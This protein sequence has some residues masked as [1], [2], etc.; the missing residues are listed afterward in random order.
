MKLH[1]L[2]HSCSFD[3]TNNL[4]AALLQLRNHTLE[5]TMWVDAICIDQAN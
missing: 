4:H 2:I 3:V 1:V 5:R